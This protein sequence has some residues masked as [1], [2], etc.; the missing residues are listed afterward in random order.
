MSL[1]AL[2]PQIVLKKIY[3]YHIISKVLSFI[4]NKFFTKANVVTLSFLMKSRVINRVKA[5]E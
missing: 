1:Y 3:I 2:L 4:D 5:K